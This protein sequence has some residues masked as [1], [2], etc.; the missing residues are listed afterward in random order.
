M[1]G[2]RI[3]VVDDDRDFAESLAEL[4]HE[5]GHEVELAFTGEDG[6]REMT[7]RHFDITF[8]DVKLPDM[9]GV[10]GFLESRKQNA[11]ARVVLMTGY[12]VEEVVQKAVAAGALGVLRKPLVMGEL[13]SF[14]DQ[15]SPNQTLLLV[16]D[17]A[18][19][20]ASTRAIL[21]DRGFRVLL[22]RTG[23]EAIELALAN[24]IDL[25]VLDL[26]L[27]LLNGLGVHEA[28]KRQGVTLP[29]IVVTAY[30]A[31]E[32][33]QIDAF[34]SLPNATCMHKPFDPAVLLSHIDELIS[35]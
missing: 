6:V 15:I 13:F 35:A 32:H 21:E 18:E 16:D 10:D 17:D 5:R 2:L 4:L 34:G 7:L 19:F 27:P 20:L 24:T 1:S 30:A 28:L 9:S 3:L 11:A 29:T 8:M 22:A 23:V 25:L 33:E 14:L 12:M 31:E 26:R